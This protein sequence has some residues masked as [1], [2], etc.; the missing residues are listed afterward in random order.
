MIASCLYPKSQHDLCLSS[1][2]LSCYSPSSPCSSFIIS[3]HHHPLFTSLFIHY[4]P[5]L[6]FSSLS[7][8]PLPFLSHFPS[9][10]PSPSFF[11]QQSARFVF[12]FFFSYFLVSF[13]HTSVVVFAPCFPEIAERVWVTFFHPGAMLLPITSHGSLILKCHDV[14]R[15]QFDEDIQSCRPRTPLWTYCIE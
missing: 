12:F 14:T 1:Y 13:L 8:L 7:P 6:N 15:S 2:P 11:K 4:R 10:P 9:S 5:L 3:P